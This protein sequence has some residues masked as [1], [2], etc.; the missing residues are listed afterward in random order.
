MERCV[1]F[2]LTAFLVLSG[3]ERVVLVKGPPDEYPPPTERG[4]SPAALHIPPGHLP[5]P[6]ECR[7]WYPD[8]PP[9][10]Q[11]PPGDCASLSRRV[12]PGAWLIRH[13]D[14]DR[15]NV[16]VSVYDQNRPGVVVV[17]RVFNAANGSF[18]S[19]RTP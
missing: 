8:M 13:P 7:I 17:I 3:C 19:E 18:V 5:P 4:G 10:Q 12:P 2:M 14:N 1:L 16:H 11:A 9:G 6:G 15:E